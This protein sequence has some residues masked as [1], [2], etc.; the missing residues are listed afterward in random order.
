MLYLIHFKNCELWG[1]NLTNIAYSSLS[2][3]ACFGCII[4]VISYIKHK[5]LN[6]LA[7]FGFG[8][9]NRCSNNEQFVNIFMH[10]PKTTYLLIIDSLHAFIPIT[11]KTFPLYRYIN[12]VLR[13]S[14][15]LKHLRTTL[16]RMLNVIIG[17]NKIITQRKMVESYFYQYFYQEVCTII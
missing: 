5:F 10:R 12:F 3:I 6:V 13:L 17:W 2:N 9:D 4:D 14:I 8:S 15:C 7:I 1:P 16:D 11:C